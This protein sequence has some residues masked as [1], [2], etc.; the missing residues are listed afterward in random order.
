MNKTGCCSTCKRETIFKTEKVFDGW[1]CIG[2]TLACALCGAVQPSEE[3]EAN[4]SSGKSKSEALDKLAGFLGETQA[5]KISA[6]ELIP[7]EKAGFCKDCRHF[8]AHLFGDRCGLKQCEVNS[9]DDCP[10][11]EKKKKKKKKES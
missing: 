3:N 4:P 10:Q 6:E 7:G 9:M 5:E 11:F 8:I 1:D 2:E